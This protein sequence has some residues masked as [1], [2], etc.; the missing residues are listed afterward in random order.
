MTN[1]S[2]PRFCDTLNLNT[3][4]STEHL[5][6]RLYEYEDIDCKTQPR[7][8]NR[9]SGKKYKYYNTLVKVKLD[10]AQVTKAQWGSRDTDIFYLDLRR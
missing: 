2:L 8:G 1:F 7:F 5:Y 10:L 3:F 4:C 6:L 9:S